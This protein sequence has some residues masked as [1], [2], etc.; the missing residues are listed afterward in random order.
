LALSAMPRTPAD[1]SDGETAMTL[2]GDFGGGGLTIL[3]G[4]QLGL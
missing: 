1:T 3:R 2:R 4:T